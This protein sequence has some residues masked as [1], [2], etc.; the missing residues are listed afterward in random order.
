MTKVSNVRVFPWPC[1]TLFCIPRYGRC[2]KPGCE[3]TKAKAGRSKQLGFKMCECGHVF[4][5]HASVTG[6]SKPTQR[7]ASEQR[8]WVLPQKQVLVDFLGSV[9]RISHYVSLSCPCAEWH[10]RMGL[11][12]CLSSQVPIGWRSS[13]E[14]LC[15]KLP[16]QFTTD[17]SRCACA[18]SLLALRILTRPHRL[19]VFGAPSTRRA[20]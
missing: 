19:S 7:P 13:N 5:A 9:L 1:L 10:V 15:I 4:D 2:E 18:P 14:K 8:G 3:C 11:I 20:P 6:G 12:L 16:I 17:A